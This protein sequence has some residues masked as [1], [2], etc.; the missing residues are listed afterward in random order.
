MPTLQIEILGS[1]PM[2]L[3]AHPKH[4]PRVGAGATKQHAQ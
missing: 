1:Q 4:F 3:L 2:G